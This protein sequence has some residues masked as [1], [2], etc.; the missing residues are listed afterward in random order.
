MIQ[1][2][3]SKTISVFIAAVPNEVYVYA[4]NPEH[5][6]QWVPSFCK[7]VKK[8]D[9]DWVVESP[10][11]AAIFRFVESN[12]LGVLDHVVKLATGVE[13]YSPM[14]VIPNGNGCEVIFTLFR[15]A[16]MTEEQH[17]ADAKLVEGD[18]RRLKEI[19]ERRPAVT[20]PTQTT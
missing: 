14:R 20:R 9:N 4:A 1:G 13:V 7:S 18:L 16:D 17:A 15:T 12:S 3:P 10:L 6:P 8:V 2:M 5:L 11:G 19:I